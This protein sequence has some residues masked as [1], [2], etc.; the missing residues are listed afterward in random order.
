MAI[1][2]G[3]ELLVEGTECVTL[4]CLWAWLSWIFMGYA[5][6]PVEKVSHFG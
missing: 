3:P 2:R 1:P 5:K 6:Q 4:F